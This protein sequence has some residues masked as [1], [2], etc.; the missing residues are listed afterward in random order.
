MAVYHKGLSYHEDITLKHDIT[1]EEIEFLINLQKEM[2]TQDTVGQAEPRFWV[3]RGTVKEYGIEDGYGDGADLVDDSSGDVVAYNLPMAAEYVREE[4]I[5]DINSTDGLIRTVSLEKGIFHPDILISWEEDGEEDSLIFDNMQE[6]ADWLNENGYDF[7]VANYK[8]TSKIFP[9]T[10]F[11]TQKAAEEHLR[12]NY[13]HYPEDAHT[14]AM[15]SWRNPETEILWKI[16]RE[17]DW[18][19]L[20]ELYHGLPEM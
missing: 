2:N 8:Q 6:L 15:T 7:R 20:G 11:L 12:K 1:E 3:I 19:R 18:K 9:D 13:Y 10:M 14:Y 5:A 17:V 16:L 4:L